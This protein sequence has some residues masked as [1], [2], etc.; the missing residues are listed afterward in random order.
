LKEEEQ[1]LLKR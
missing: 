1:I